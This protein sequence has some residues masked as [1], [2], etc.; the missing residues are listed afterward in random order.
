[1]AVTTYNTSLPAAQRYKNGYILVLTRELCEKK[2]ING[3]EISIISLKLYGFRK[4]SGY[5]GLEFK[6]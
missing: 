5:I 2:G 3:I 1:M 6:K 4:G